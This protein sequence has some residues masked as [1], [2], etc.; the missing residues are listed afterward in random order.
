MFL[1]IRSGY[2]YG[3]FE[4]W[5]DGIMQ[6]GREYLKAVFIKYSTIHYSGIPYLTILFMRTKFTLTLFSD[7]LYQKQGIITIYFFIFYFFT[8]ADPNAQEADS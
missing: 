3:A 4:Y 6:T 7:I 5:S 2:L 8:Q 1:Y